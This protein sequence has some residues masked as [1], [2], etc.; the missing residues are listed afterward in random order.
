M[1]P[2]RDSERAALAPEVVLGDANTNRT[3]TIAPPKWGVAE[4]PTHNNR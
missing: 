1:L 2:A 4:L 3:S